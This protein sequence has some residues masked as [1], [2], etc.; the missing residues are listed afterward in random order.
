MKL[1]VGKKYQLDRW[2]DNGWI[3][4]KFIGKHRFF[5]EDQDGN[6]GTWEFTHPW[7]EYKEPKK[8]SERIREIELS[9]RLGVGAAFAGRSG[10][11]EAIIT[12]LDEQYE[13][14]NLLK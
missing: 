11:E 3:E 13:N 10:T 9:G 4:V 2:G 12:Y 1:E 7:I 14:G 5:A 6:E 8:P